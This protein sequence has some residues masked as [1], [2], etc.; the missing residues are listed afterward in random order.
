MVIILIE[1][2]REIG[3]L[4]SVQQSVYEHVHMHVY[5][6]VRERRKEGECVIQYFFFMKSWLLL[7]KTQCEGL[8]HYLYC[9]F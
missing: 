5:Y 8:L 9:N 7:F 4:K 2:F 3:A 6:C 1:L